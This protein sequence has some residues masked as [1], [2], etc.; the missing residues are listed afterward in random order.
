LLQLC[1]K[2]IPKLQRD[3][4]ANDNLH[5][6]LFPRPAFLV[7]HFLDVFH[8]QGHRKLVKW[9]DAHLLESIRQSQHNNMVRKAPQAV[10]YKQLG[11]GKQ[12]GILD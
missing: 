3:I 2:G 9:F 8:P 6:S 12:D 11:Q 4:C 7:Q 10:Q 1:S 5:G